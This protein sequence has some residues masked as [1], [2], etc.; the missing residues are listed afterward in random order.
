M[1]TL[2]LTRLAL[3]LAVRLVLTAA[4]LLAALAGLVLLLLPLARAA[5]AGLVLLAATLV[6]A[7]LL[8]VRLVLFLV[9]HRLRSLSC[10]L[11]WPRMTI[12]R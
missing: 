11:Q 1:P 7:L 9:C 6:A 2:A 10:L 12:R 4:L 5:L 8:T 3:L